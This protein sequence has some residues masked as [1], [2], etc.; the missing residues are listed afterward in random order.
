MIRI[1]VL[2]RLLQIWSGDWRVLSILL[3]HLI[4]VLPVRHLTKQF[5]TCVLSSTT[6][7]G[8]GNGATAH[9]YYGLAQRGLSV[10]SENIVLIGVIRLKGGSQATHLVIFCSKYYT[11]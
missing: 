6:K 11:F 7:E 4:E 1:K 9:D 10:H 2:V 5:R 8:N 3:V